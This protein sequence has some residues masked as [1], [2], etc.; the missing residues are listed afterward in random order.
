MWS[1]PGKCVEKA[2]C[3]P[4]ALRFSHNY[5]H[6]WY[7]ISI[8]FMFVHLFISLGWFMSGLGFLLMDWRDAMASDYAHRI[9]SSKDHQR[10]SFQVF[11]LAAIVY[12]VLQINPWSRAWYSFVFWT[13]KLIELYEFWCYIINFA[14]HCCTTMHSK[15]PTFRREFEHG[16]SANKV[17]LAISYGQLSL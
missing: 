17:I 15:S 13:I 11:L 5:A 16:L 2:F 10:K 1:S 7:V 14:F 6:I 4:S 9:S 12:L 8:S 3:M